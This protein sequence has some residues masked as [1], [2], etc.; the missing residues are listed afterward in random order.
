MRRLLQVPRARCFSPYFCHWFL[1]N[2]FL[3]DVDCV[4]RS[5]RNPS[6][7][8]HGRWRERQPTC[9]RPSNANDQFRGRDSFVVGTCGQKKSKVDVQGVVVHIDRDF[10]TYTIQRVKR[11]SLQSVAKL[12][13][14]SRSVE[15]SFEGNA[16]MATKIAISKVNRYNWPSILLLR[17][18]L[19]NHIRRFVFARRSKL[20]SVTGVIERLQP[21]GNNYHACFEQED[22]SIKYVSHSPSL[23]LQTFRSIPECIWSVYGWT[24]TTTWKK[25]S[26][27]VGSLLC[28]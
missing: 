26:M 22:A 20:I 10:D 12:M 17:L 15:C 8:V 2:R 28:S 24:R 1:G 5:S 6:S 19:R 14:A 3:L 4:G 18:P 16:S 25:R 11:Q 7:S 23:L 13:Q 9:L 21:V 27:K